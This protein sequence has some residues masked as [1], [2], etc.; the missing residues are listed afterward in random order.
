MQRSPALPN[1]APATRRR[2]LGLIAQLGPGARDAVPVITPLLKG[3]FESVRIAAAEAIGA[4]GPDAKA[5]LPDLQPL[6]HSDSARVRGAATYAMTRIAPGDG[7]FAEGLPKAVQSKDHARSAVLAPQVRGEQA[8][9][10][11][12]D[13]TELARHN[14]DEDIRATAWYA[15]REIGVPLPWLYVNRRAQ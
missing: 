13:L 9:K 7:Q 4:I 3:G 14:V 11:R 5:A 12:D 15:L 2:I 1:A 8:P 10:T 6:L